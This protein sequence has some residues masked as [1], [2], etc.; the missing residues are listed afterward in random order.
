YG[1]HRDLHS[2]PTR[3]SSDLLTHTKSQQLTSPTKQLSPRVNSGAALL[4]CVCVCACVRAC[5]RICVCVCVRACVHMCV[6]V[7]V[8]ACVCMCACVQAVNMFR[9][10]ALARLLWSLPLPF[11]SDPFQQLRGLFEQ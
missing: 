10:D 3:R 1:D 2:F 5:M 7:C 4:L 9:R 6:R 11:S 8:H